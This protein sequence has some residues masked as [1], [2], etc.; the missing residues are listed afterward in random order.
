MHS[1]WSWRILALI[2]PTSCR[3][4]SSLQSLSAWS[5]PLR[6]CWRVSPCTQICNCMD[7]WD[8]CDDPA[9]H[10]CHLYGRNHWSGDI[11]TPQHIPHTVG[12]NP[13]QDLITRQSC[14][15]VCILASVQFLQNKIPTPSRHV[16][17][18]HYVLINH[19]LNSIDLLHDVL[20]VISIKQSPP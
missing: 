16:H 17:Q 19:I 15:C 14:G 20:S 10:L 5:Y 6:S 9:C 13:T 12:I 11:F 8:D 3:Q 4:C 1:S 2:R 7:H 18:H